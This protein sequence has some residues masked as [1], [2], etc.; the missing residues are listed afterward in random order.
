M[1]RIGNFFDQLTYLIMHMIGV[2]KLNE[3]LMQSFVTFI[4][5]TFSH[6]YN[7]AFSK[8]LFLLLDINDSKDSNK[9]IC[10]SSLNPMMDIFYT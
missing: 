9:T 4:L 6:C 1:E 10:L 7:W 2:W 5:L 8:A 3:V